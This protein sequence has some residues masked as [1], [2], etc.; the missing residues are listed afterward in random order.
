MILRFHLY[1]LLRG[2]KEGSQVDA[3]TRGCN[4]FPNAE[5]LSSI[6]V[7]VLLVTVVVGIQGLVSAR[8]ECVH[9]GFSEKHHE[10]L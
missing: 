2:R 9:L 5:I 1:R 8:V 7:P 4:S 6:I 3:V 10:L